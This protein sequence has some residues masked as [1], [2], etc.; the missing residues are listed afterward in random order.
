MK[1]SSGIDWPDL[2]QPGNTAAF[3]PVHQLVVHHAVE[4][5]MQAQVSHINL[6]LTR[7]R[8]LPVMKSTI[9]FKVMSDSLDSF[10]G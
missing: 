4:S 10:S 1:L 5:R 9:H 8:Q 7:G 2:L 3:D 6:D